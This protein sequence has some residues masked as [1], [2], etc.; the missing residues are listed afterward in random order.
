MKK[1]LIFAIAIPFAAVASMLTIAGITKARADVSGMNITGDK[2]VLYTGTASSVIVP[3]GVKEISPEAFAGNTYVTDVVIENGVT[4]IGRDAFKNCSSLSSISIP[5]SVTMIGPSAFQSCQALN[6]VSLGSG[7]SDL[8]AGTFSDCDSLKTVDISSSNPYYTYANG[9]IYSKDGSRLVQYLSGHGAY[10]YSIPG[11]VTDIDR[12]A[13]WGADTVREIIVPGMSSIPDYAFTNATGL[14]SIEFQI[15]T[16]S[17]GMRSVSGCPNLAQV[18]I[19]VS[20]ANIDSTAFEGCPDTLYINCEDISKAADFAASKGYAAGDMDLYDSSVLVAAEADRIKREGQQEVPQYKFETYNHSE[21]KPVEANTDV[22]ISSTEVVSDRAYVIVGGGELTV[23]NGSDAPKAQA[24][25]TEAASVE[26]PYAHYLDQTLSEYVFPSDITSVG[27]FG[28]ARTRLQNVNIPE[29][30]TSI[31]KG[32]FY[33]CD[34]LTEVNIPSSVS[35]IGEKAFAYTPWYQNWEND[36]SADDFLIV[37]DGV[38]IG[39]KGDAESPEI[40][41]TVKYIAPGVFNK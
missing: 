40:P 8:G 9:A 35:T 1:K 17:I 26:K 24:D 38:L 13:F 2:L 18:S 16:N 7:L 20:V 15:P 10:L 14:E 33:H 30:V 34:N 11:N 19:P 4:K 25:A 37:G 27:D 36:S 21:P 12:Y 23:N 6:D 39:Y 28:F 5:D 3:S 41:G 29:G 32:A 31:G 22:E